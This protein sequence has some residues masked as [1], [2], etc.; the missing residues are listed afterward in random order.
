MI[1]VGWTQ[2]PQSD[3]GGTQL[4][5]YEIWWNQGP[6]TNT[7]V[8]YSDVNHATFS[9]TISSVTTSSNYEFYIIAKNIVGSS[10]PSDTVQI[11]A[12]VVPN[13]PT[14]VMRVPDS[15]TQTTIDL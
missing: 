11:W 5:G 1:V 2:N 15:N 10:E 6:I 12:A 9:Q 3:Y 4:T 14:S 13:A 8:K 7:F